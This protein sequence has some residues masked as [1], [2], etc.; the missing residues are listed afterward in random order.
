MTEDLFAE[1]EEKRR[2]LLEIFEESPIKKIHGVVGANGPGGGKVPPEIKWAMNLKIVAWREQGG[3]VHKDAI[4]VTKQVDD[5]ELQ[6]LQD[7]IKS[8][9]VITFTGKICPESPFGDARALLV[10]Y[11]GTSADKEL[12]EIL[13]RYVRP[14]EIYDETL[15]KLSLNKS[16]DLF[17]GKFEWNGS[18]IELSFS[19]DESG[20]PDAAIETAKSLINNM[21]DWATQVDEFAVKELLDLKNKI[22]LDDDESEVTKEEFVNL[23]TIK[24]ITTYPEGEFEFWHDDG[25]LFWGHSILVSGSLSEG[26]TDADIPG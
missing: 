11:V 2:R 19:L 20:K 10:D 9:S 17:E 8:K 3:A 14:I 22:W 24:S 15:G 13:S 23:M 6:E 18:Q 16:V 5:K 12:A 4:I 21:S 26:M 7:R 1:A 25:E